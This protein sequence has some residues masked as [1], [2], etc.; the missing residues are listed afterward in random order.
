[1]TSTPLPLATVAPA[2]AARRGLKASLLPLVVALLLAALPVYLSSYGAD[3]VLRIM[4]YAIF[5]LSLELLVGTTGL[6]SLGH[7]GFFGIAAY[8]TVLASGDNAAS[9]AWLLPL[10]M[11]AAGLYALVTGALSLRTRGVYFIMVTLAFAQMAYF[12]FH[13]TPIGGGSDG[14]FLTSRPVLAMGGATLLD[15]EKSSHVYYLALACLAGTYALLAAV[16]RSRFGHAL[17]GIRINEQRMRAAGYDTYRYKLAAFVLA[18]MLAGVAGF[19]MAAKNG[20]VNPELLSWH[21]SGGVLMM[22]IL[23]GLGSLRG[24]VLGAIAFVLLKEFYASSAILGSLADRW[25]LTLGLTMI[26]FVA[27]MPQGLIGL[28]RRWKR[29]PEAGHAH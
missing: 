20:A 9:V 10:S 17:A 15:L 25:Q 29:T 24:A 5:A 8:V 2:A 16:L 3:L 18:A 4:V 14:M 27:L 26:L 22:I 6:V 23:G 7:A 12:V 28:A 13:D 11:L 19:L 1:M 21:E